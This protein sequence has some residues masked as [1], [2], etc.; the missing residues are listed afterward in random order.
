MG[1]RCYDYS[2]FADEEAETLSP[3]HKASKSAGLGNEPVACDG[4]ELCCLVSTTLYNWDKGVLV[5]HHMK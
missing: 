2:H 5:Q 3:R 1:R 4:I